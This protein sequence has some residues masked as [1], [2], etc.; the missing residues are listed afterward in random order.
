MIVMFKIKD[1]GVLTVA[2]LIWAGTDAIPRWQMWS[3]EVQGYLLSYVPTPRA[4]R[5][6][7][8]RLWAMQ[9]QTC[10]SPKPAPCSAPQVFIGF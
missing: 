5:N 8:C 4:I 10:Q 9:K 7:S 3:G 2:I 1:Q 6:L